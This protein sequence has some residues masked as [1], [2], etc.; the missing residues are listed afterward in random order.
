[1][2]LRVKCH[3]TLGILVGTDGHVMVPGDKYHKAHWTYGSKHGNGYR[4]ITYK[5]IEYLVHRLVLE[6]FV[7]PCP[8][9]FECDH[10][11]RIRDDNSLENLRWV[12]KTTNQRNRI[13]NDRCKD[14]LG[15]HY[16]EDPK[17]ANRRN[18]ALRYAQLKDNADFLAAHRSGYKK[19]SDEHKKTHRRVLCYDRVKWVPNKEALVLLQLPVKERIYADK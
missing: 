7:G 8:E 15:I 19:W 6:T 1:M 13:S 17:E 12:S 14:R 16:Y 3:P 2:N 11:N 9:G 10:I 5:G 18:C 4:T